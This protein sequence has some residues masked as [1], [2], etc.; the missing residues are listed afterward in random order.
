MERQAS[1]FGDEALAPA[2][3][4]KR[5]AKPPAA[6]T[7]APLPPK[8]PLQVLPTAF[9][10]PPE[11]ATVIPTPARLEVRKIPLPPRRFYHG[12]K[13]EE[14]HA[15]RKAL[16][17]AREAYN[18]ACTDDLCASCGRGRASA[19]DRSRL[20]ENIAALTRTVRELIESIEGTIDP[21]KAAA[22]LDAVLEQFMTN[23]IYAQSA[24]LNRLYGD[25]T[26]L[27]PQ[28][29]DRHRVNV[30]AAFDR[31]GKIFNVEYSELRKSLTSIVGADD[32]KSRT[33]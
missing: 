8:L 30:F 1:L 25:I 31:L 27:D 23:V 18:N 15:T 4:A 9:P 16:E 6:G 13:V 33:R 28:N 21:A 11:G 22:V 14:L 12:V 17:K 19:L 32:A 26:T 29:R 2:K 20:G 24:E 10:E 7:P 3:P 5:R